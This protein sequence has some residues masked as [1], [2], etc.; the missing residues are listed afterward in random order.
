MAARAS[1]LTK[2]AD[3]KTCGAPTTTGGRCKNHLKP[4]MSRCWRHKN[5]GATPKPKPS[6][7][8][9]RWYDER[10]KLTTR[11]GTPAPAG[12]G[13]PVTVAARDIRPGDLVAGYRVEKVEPGSKKDTVRIHVGNGVRMIGRAD[14]PVEVIRGSDSKARPGDPPPKPP[15]RKEAAKPNI[16]EARRRIAEF[17]AQIG[18]PADLGWRQ[19]SIVSPNAFRS[20]LERDHAELE[21]KIAEYREVINLVERGHWNKLKQRADSS[22]GYLNNLRTVSKLSDLRL[23]PATRAYTIETLQQRIKWER[24]EAEEHEEAIRRM[25]TRRVPD[26]SGHD[27]QMPGEETLEKIEAIRSAGKVV[28]ELVDRRAAELADVPLPQPGGYLALRDAR[29]RAYERLMNTPED[30]PNFAAIARANDEAAEVIRA[31]FRGKGK[32]GEHRAQARREIL[33]QLRPMGGKIAYAESSV[34]AAISE[35]DRVLGNFPADW[36]ERGRK[37]PLRAVTDAESGEVDPGNLAFGR[38]HYNSHGN[39]LVTYR[40]N[41]RVAT[42]ELTHMMETKVPGLPAAQWAYWAI[43]NSEAGPGG[44]REWSTKGAVTRM[45]DAVPGSNYDS[46]EVTRP[47]TF[48]HPYVGK[49]YGQAGPQASHWEV[50]SMG[51]EAL[52][53]GTDRRHSPADQDA[54]MEAFILGVWSVL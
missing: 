4:G 23:S 19:E 24:K 12:G 41:A 35:V 22:D 18:N 29:D 37:T 49:F 51:S 8:R 48:A 11:R 36:L 39:I 40:D 7:P 32:L 10:G 30:H 47:D 44:A 28:A 52:V 26:V 15:I 17:R 50:A 21:R 34:P 16:E 45:A 25:S 43:R 53:S 27:A 3:G 33:A 14:Q 6:G 1:T 38:A 5:G 31:Y 20:R 9:T 13:T 54:D 46:S 2:L 42:H